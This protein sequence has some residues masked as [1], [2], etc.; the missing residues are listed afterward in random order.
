MRKTWMNAATV[1]FSKAVTKKLLCFGILA[2]LLQCKS[3]ERPKDILLLAMDGKPTLF[4][5]LPSA[6]LQ[7][8]FFFGPECPLSEN[9][10]AHA[11]KM[12]SRYGQDSVRFTAIIPGNYDDSTAVASFVSRFQLRLP[13]YRDTS[14]QLTHFMGA[15]ITPEVFVYA[16]EALIYHGA[17]DNWAVTLGT[18]RRKV[19]EHYL[20]NA[21]MAYFAN[22]WISPDHIPAVGCFIE[23][24]QR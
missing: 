8:F 7:V 21:L 1:T 18:K 22:Q 13:V 2:F 20:E 19:T 12:A 9:Y 6:Q 16:G 11:N 5:H 4:N 17:I 14:W 15:T 23:P 10:T 24:P 3:P